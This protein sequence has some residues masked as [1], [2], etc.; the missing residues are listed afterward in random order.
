MQNTIAGLIALSGM[1]L[2]VYVAVLLALL[3]LAFA[4]LIAHVRLMWQA[5]S[6]LQHSYE[7]EDRRMV[8]AATQPRP[9]EAPPLRRV[10]PL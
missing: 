9:G 2:L 7:R 4:A 1:A 3:L 10:G 8:L 6:W 5:G